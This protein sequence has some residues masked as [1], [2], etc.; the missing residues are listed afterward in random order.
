MF[1]NFLLAVLLM[2]V[3]AMSTAFA[4]PPL[5]PPSAPP[6]A[7]AQPSK[8]NFFNN[9]KGAASQIAA[10][11][12]TGITKNLTLT[13]LALSKN[14][15]K[16]ALAVA[17]GLAL[18]YLV[19]EVLRLMGT[20][21]SMFT[22]LFDVGIPCILAF[23]LISQYGTYIGM[24]DEFLG[25]FRYLGDPASGPNAPI[26]SAATTSIM[27]MYG[28]I[29]ATIGGTVQQ[30][31]ANLNTDGWFSVATAGFYTNLVDMLVTMIFALIVLV[32]VLVGM[33]DVVGLLLMG[34]FLFA[35]GVAF[36][37]LMIA[38]VVTPWTRDYFTK[39]V[40]FLVASAV[41]TGVIQ[42]IMKIG[43]AMFDSLTI[44]GYTS[45]DS[46]T[47]VTMVIVAILVMAINSLISQAPAIAGAL[48]P[49]HLG[50]TKGAGGDVH[51]ASGM[52]KD[53]AKAV[54][55]IAGRGVAKGGK[56]AIAAIQKAR[57][58]SSSP[59]QIGP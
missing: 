46:P 28:G 26:A 7:N 55:G 1:K 49:G 8:G 39:W 21:N 6:T 19:V 10:K 52:A 27:N 31:L 20:K 13:G 9:L 41:L 53:N 36:G 24:F 17:G 57:G 22:P 12:S 37:P 3:N 5:P 56:M 54:G 35:I 58:K 2:S 34:P 43:S 15:V 50:A 40:Q 42:I 23:L 38:G 47:A 59:L 44:T 48:V 4:A 14:L 33:A 29:L 25:L 51:K 45:A 11:I 18:L 32:F 16:P 30:S